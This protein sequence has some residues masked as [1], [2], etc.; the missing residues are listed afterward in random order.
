MSIQKNRTGWSFK[1]DRFHDPHLLFPTGD[2][3]YSVSLLKS[4]IRHDAGHVQQ[5]LL[6]KCTAFNFRCFSYRFGHDFPVLIKSVS[7]EN[8]KHLDA[9]V[10][11]IH[12]RQFR[13][14]QIVHR[15]AGIFLSRPASGHGNIYPFRVQFGG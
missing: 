2:P 13:I 14:C 10:A 7:I 11:A 6:F 8:P 1:L 9:F 12:E 5:A 3:T 4:I 15:K